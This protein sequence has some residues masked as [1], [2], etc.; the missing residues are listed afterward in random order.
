MCLGA[1]VREA[2]CALFISGP[3]VGAP[4]E[5][6]SLSVILDA[7]LTGIDIDE[8]TLTLDFDH[9]VLT[10]IDAMASALLSGSSM[11]PNAAGGSA[12]ASFF[13]TQFPLPSGVS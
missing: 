8:L 7:P 1:T 5:E 3:A 4:G 6:L 10:G 2:H 13:G 9:A 12:V 11:K